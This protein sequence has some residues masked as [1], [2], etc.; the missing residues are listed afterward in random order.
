MLRPWEAYFSPVIMG[1]ENVDKD[2]PAL[3]VA[4]HTLYGLL[5]VPLYGHKLYE[6]KEILLRSLGDDMHYKVPIWREI[7]LKLGLVR[8]SREN[9]RELM[10]MGEHILVFPGGTREIL[11]KKSELYH[12]IWGN[13]MG[14]AQMAIENQYDIIP[15]AS[16]G[17]EQALDIVSDSDDFQHTLMGK[18]LNATGLSRLLRGQDYIP[19]LV[20]GLGHTFMPKPVKF[21][22]KFGTRI[23]T[24]RYKGMAEDK[25]AVLMLRTEVELSIDRML[26]DLLK[27]QAS[28]ND[29]GILRRLVLLGDQRRKKKEQEKKD[30][31]KE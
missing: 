21:Y 8:A 14:F 24:Q 11:K 28:D 20:E 25:N 5:D 1:L 15:I 27:M 4:N 17:P 3:Y 12:L 18:F 26:I 23:S 22:I 30:R 19:P 7:M 29:M 6:E 31:K 10:K 16:V 9:C 13:R 2:H